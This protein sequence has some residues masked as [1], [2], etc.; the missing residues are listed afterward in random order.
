MP[1]IHLFQYSNSTFQ[2]KLQTWATSAEYI[3]EILSLYWAL[4]IILYFHQDCF[5]KKA[6]AEESSA[7]YKENAH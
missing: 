5:L 6:I 1:S 2:I 3:S 4:I 7:F